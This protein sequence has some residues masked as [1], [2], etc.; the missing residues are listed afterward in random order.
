MRIITIKSAKKINKSRSKKRFKLLHH[1]R[2][3]IIL[4]T[5]ENNSQLGQ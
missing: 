1:L 2:K 5:I 4:K 3:L